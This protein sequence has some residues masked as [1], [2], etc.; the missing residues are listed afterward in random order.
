MPSF[1][2]GQVSTSWRSYF[3]Y[4]LALK[5]PIPLLLLWGMAAV[6]GAPRTRH[7][8]LAPVFAVPA[9]APAMHNVVLIAALLLVCPHL[10][11]KAIWAYRKAVSLWPGD[12]RTLYSLARAY[13]R[14]E[15]FDDAIKWYKEAI[16]LMPD[17]A[18]LHYQL[19]VIYGLVGRYEEALSQFKSA[20]GSD[21]EYVDAYYATA[22]LC[23]EHLKKDGEAAHYYKLYL[24]FRPDDP[25]APQIQRWIAN[26]E[27]REGE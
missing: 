12:I 2:C 25:Q 20:I 11:D 6:V 18:S 24:I 4:V 21:P 27:S 10:G 26:V 9:L 14:V 17:Q 23:K 16:E 15:K 3:L 22:Y 8:L 5:T 1:L 7:A 13:A 19:G